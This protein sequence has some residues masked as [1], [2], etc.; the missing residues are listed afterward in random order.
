MWSPWVG[1]FVPTVVAV[2]WPGGLPLQHSSFT[3]SEKNLWNFEQKPRCRFEMPVFNS[4]LPRGQSSA[5]NT[6]NAGDKQHLVVAN[7]LFFLLLLLQMRF[8]VLLQIFLQLL[9]SSLCPGKWAGHRRGGRRWSGQV[10]QKWSKSKIK[11]ALGD[12]FLSPMFFPCCPGG[13]F[14]FFFF[15]YDHAQVCVTEFQTFLY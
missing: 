10:T 11:T 15:T 2:P 7:G 1:R 9:F 13:D 3:A 4:C 12:S 14:F 8:L 6:E 5:R